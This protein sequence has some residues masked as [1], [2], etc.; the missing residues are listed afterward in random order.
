MAPRFL[1]ILTGRNLP[2]IWQPREP[3]PSTV[4]DRTIA[5][6]TRVLEQTGI[7]EFLSHLTLIRYMRQWNS[8]PSKSWATLRCASAW[9]GT[10][11]EPVP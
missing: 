3:Q 7:G 2:K 10:G 9:F 11:G 6:F 8:K 5:D 4:N 1:T